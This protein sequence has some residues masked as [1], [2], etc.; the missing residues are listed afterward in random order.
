M[1]INS[2]SSNFVF[3][4]PVNFIHAD[5]EKKY[6]PYVMRMPG[7]PYDTVSNMM[8]AHIQSISMPSLSMTPVSQ[9][10]TGGKTQTYKSGQPVPDYFTKEMTVT[11]KAVDGY[12]NYWIFL[13]NT[14]C[15]LDLSDERLYLEDMYVRVID[16]EGHV[17]QTIR[18]EKPMLTSLSEVSLSYSDNNPDFNTFDCTFTYN[19]LE[20]M[21]EH[22]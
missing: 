5:I 4:F 10:R 17:L 9:T 21:V 22:A 6:A 7:L 18:F 13:E 19:A 8:N 16:Q 1:I 3:N 20:V 11:M 15:F 2:R 12:I 14:L